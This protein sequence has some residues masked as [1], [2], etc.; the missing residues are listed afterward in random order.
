MIESV[1]SFIDS[2]FSQDNIKKITK[3]FMFSNCTNLRFTYNDQLQILNH[4]KSYTSKAI[5]LPAY[6]Y[7]SRSQIPF[8]VEQQPSAQNGSMSRVV[9][10]NNLHCGNRTQDEDYSYFIINQAAL[11]SEQV[12]E[13]K[14]WKKKSF[15]TDSHH[16]NL[17]LSDAIFFCLGNGLKDGFTPTMHLEAIAGVP[18]REYQP[19][20]SMMHHE[21]TKLYYARKEKEY[22]NFGKG[23]REKLLPYI[24]ELDRNN[25][26]FLEL[27]QKSTSYFFTLKSFMTAGLHKL[28]SDPTFFI[29]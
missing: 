15:G 7:N 10:E 26:S 21:R 23:T 18:Y 6:T 4:L 17:F 11:A 13:L 8:R 27:S 19:F 22:D 1:V 24:Q 28:K 29:R 20:K 9:F 16:S 12:K 25:F 14:I 2:Y 3:L 5:F